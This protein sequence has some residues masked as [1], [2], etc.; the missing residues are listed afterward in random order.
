M[1]SLLHHTV[2]AA[3]CSVGT[4]VALG[5][6]VP[7]SLVHAVRKDAAW[8]SSHVI[9]MGTSR[10]TASLPEDCWS[11]PC[12]GTQDTNVLASR[13]A[14]GSQSVEKKQKVSWRP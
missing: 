10:L 4:S 2:V 11:V 12:T 3:S 1:L 5:G 7:S 8:I 6:P 9:L 13:S 14:P